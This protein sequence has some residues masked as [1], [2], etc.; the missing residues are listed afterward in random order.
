MG[1]HASGGDGRLARDTGQLQVL[2]DGLIFSGRRA[3]LTPPL[4]HGPLV[5]RRLDLPVAVDTRIRAAAADAGVSVDA[6]LRRW[7]VAGLEAAE[8]TNPHE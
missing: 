8:E 5:H 3:P 4:D 1:A 7:V 2:L 6:L